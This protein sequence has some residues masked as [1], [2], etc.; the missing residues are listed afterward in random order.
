MF[1]APPQYLLPTPTCK[2]REK[3]RVLKL[4]TSMIYSRLIVFTFLFMR[5]NI[6]HIVWA[7]KATVRNVSFKFEGCS[8]PNV[9]FQVFGHTLVF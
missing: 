9:F 4:N 3:A 1:L 8:I 2:E 6:S 7:S 5:S